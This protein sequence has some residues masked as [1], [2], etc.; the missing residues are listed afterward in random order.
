[1]RRSYGKVKAHIYDRERLREIFMSA[2]ALLV[3]SAVSLLATGGNGAKEDLEAMQGKW[4]VMSLTTNGEEQPAEELKDLRLEIKGN[5]YLITYRGET[6]SRTFKLQPTKK[7]K[8]MDITYDDGPNKGKTGH[9]IYELDGDTLRICRHT[10]PEMER[11]KEF[12]A[13]SG[14]N[15][16][17]IVWKRDR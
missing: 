9:T 4:R 10:Q 5:K 14:S 17:L 3:I 15:R 12:R 13:E 6:V 11:P 16:T 2:G 1:V 7:P 8:A